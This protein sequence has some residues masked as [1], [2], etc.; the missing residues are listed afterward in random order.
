MFRNEVEDFP[1]DTGSVERSQL[2]VIQAAQVLVVCQLQLTMRR[3][4]RQ[5]G[6]SG[7]DEVDADAPVLEL[8]DG[9][10]G[11]LDNGQAGDGAGWSHLCEQIREVFEVVV[12]R[13]VA[14]SGNEGIE[15]GA[16]AKDTQAVAAIGEDLA[17]CISDK[18][19]VVRLPCAGNLADEFISNTLQIIEHL[20]SVSI[21]G[22]VSQDNT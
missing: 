19:I 17:P 2:P 15:V 10:K 21:K 13:D 4:L 20:L 7:E 12:A 3:K 14:R 6:D 5:G 8:D 16:G 22:L 18:D 9:D 1:G 11:V